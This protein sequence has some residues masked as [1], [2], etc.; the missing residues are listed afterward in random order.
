MLVGLV[1]APFLSSFSC[2]GSEQSDSEEG[3]S[4]TQGAAGFLCCLGPVKDGHRPEPPVCRFV[5]A[6]WM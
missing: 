1:E 2:Y 4:V 5:T 6:A 3:C